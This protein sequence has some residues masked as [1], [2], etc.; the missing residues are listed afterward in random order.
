M[1][2]ENTEAAAGHERGDIAAAEANRG[3]GIEHGI[4]QDARGIIVSIHRPGREIIGGNRIVWGERSGN[5]FVNA[6][7]SAGERAID[8]ADEASAV[9]VI[10]TI[11]QRALFHGAVELAAANDFEGIGHAAAKLL[12]GVGAAGESGDCERRNKKA[13]GISHKNILF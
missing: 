9:G 1:R 11:K 7:A 12:F 13:N 8:A 10:R 6:N 3:V 4:F 2:F 5:H